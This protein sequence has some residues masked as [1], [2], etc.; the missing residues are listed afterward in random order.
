M[1]P[2]SD[3]VEAKSQPHWQLP[4]L[5][6]DR[7]VGGVA[8]GISEEIGVDPLVVR[9]AFVVLTAAGGWGALLYGAAWLV[10]SQTDAADAAPRQPK[11]ANET[12]RL[13]GVGLVVFGLL[14]LSREFATVF[15]DSLVWPMALFAAG[16]AVANQRGVDIGLGLGDHPSSDDRSAFL[17]RIGAGALL[18][19]ASVWLAV[20]LNFDFATARDT[21]LVVGVLVAGM[22][23]VLGPWV[24][25]LIND[26]TE[27]R[28]ARIRSEEKATVAA[29]LHDSV[30]QT[31]T[32]I[33]RRA[34]DPQVVGLA[35]KQERELRNWLYG[36][37]SATD[38]RSFRAAI[39]AALAEVEELHTV[40]V[41]V[42]VVGD[43]VVDER[44]L[45]VVAATREAVTNA[46][47][48]SRAQSID[49]FV[50][51][52]STSVDVFVRDTGV[53]FDPSTVPPD[54]RGLADSIV[55]RLDRL[56]GTAKVFSEPGEGTEVELHLDHKLERKLS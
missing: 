6:T 56:G 22:G 53:G 27:E 20:S 26:L 54:R 11:A 7:L 4:A 35:R 43:A 42:V 49:V 19:L 25:A 31:L 38:P 5:S 28:R 36:Q 16:V 52:A 14:L 12:N 33:Q 9:A 17:V 24:V 32:L 37:A 41:D 29:H 2:V 15:V 30:L 8:A 10:M 3:N 21:I 39:E 13:L 46:A 40:P 34:N 48:H 47:V 1:G 45:G 51:V 50:E 44:L 55:G 18:V 23:V